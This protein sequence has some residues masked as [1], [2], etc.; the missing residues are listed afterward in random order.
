MYSV[1]GMTVEVFFGFDPF[2]HDHVHW[3]PQSGNKA[4]GKLK[5]S[6]GSQA[7]R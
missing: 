2:D 4:H 7:I 6:I 3:R 1:Y 5:G